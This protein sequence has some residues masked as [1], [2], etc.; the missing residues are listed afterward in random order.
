MFSVASTYKALHEKVR[1]TIE[2]EVMVEVWKL[3][4]GKGK[5]HVWF[6]L[7]DHLYGLISGG[8]RNFVSEDK[9]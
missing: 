9:K 7:F 4:V 6:D 5:L 3:Q 8:F 1:G 2:D